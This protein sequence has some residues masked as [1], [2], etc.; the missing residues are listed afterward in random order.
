M[1]LKENKNCAAAV[2]FVHKLQCKLSAD[3]KQ[4]GS[5]ALRGVNGSFT[6]FT[7]C[8]E[9]GAG[10]VNDSVALH[11]GNVG[12]DNLQLQTTTMTNNRQHGGKK[13]WVISIHRMGE[14]KKR[15]KEK[16]KKRQRSEH[17]PYLLRV[18]KETVASWVKQDCTISQRN[19]DKKLFSLNFCSFTNHNTKLHAWLHLNF[20]KI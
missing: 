12:L 8:I 15:V 16:K 9:G 4:K 18:L 19:T 13:Q 5:R 11:D 17:T 2:M 14:K 3:R 6:Y 10:R 1:W 7:T 20:L